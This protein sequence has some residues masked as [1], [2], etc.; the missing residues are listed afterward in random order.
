[1]I[2]DNGKQFKLA[3]SAI[4]SIWKTIDKGDDVLNYVTTVGTKWSFI[5]ELA[6]WQ[7]GFYERMVQVV[8]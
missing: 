2:S 7:G 5:T 1:M 3:S 8:N 4:D 6:P